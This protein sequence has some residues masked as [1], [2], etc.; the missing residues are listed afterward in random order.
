LPATDLHQILG[1]VY[2]VDPDRGLRAPLARLLE[3]AQ[4][5]VHAFDDAERFLADFDRHALA[6][7][8]TEVRLPGIGGLDLQQRL[9]ATAVPLP[10][11]FLTAHGDVPA[12][13]AAMKQGAVDFLVQP[14]DPAPL[15]KLVEDV[16]ARSRRS[17]DHRQTDLPSA[18]RASLTRREV[19]VLEAIVGG[20]LNKQ[21]AADLGIS[22]KTVE[23]HRANLMAKLRAR[24]VAELI[25][26]VLEV[27]PA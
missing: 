17:L 11:V 18:V 26:I 9:R 5:R 15:C 25:R 13:V 14:F 23:V 12:A 3:Q 19:Q 24:T 2:L 8:I 16:L 1:T 7:L 6:C 10:V 4:Y 20:R 21:I 22:I 27:E